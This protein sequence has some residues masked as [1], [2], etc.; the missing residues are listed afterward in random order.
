MLGTSEQGAIFFSRKLE[1]NKKI[2]MVI[3]LGFLLFLVSMSACE[4]PKSLSWTKYNLWLANN[5]AV[6]HKTKETNEINLS[7]QH[8]PSGWLAY[9]ELENSQLP[10]KQ[11]LLD[12]IREFY[13]C[14]LHFRISLESDPAK[15]KLLYYNIKDD[16]DYKERIEM[17]SFHA[18]EFIFI[19]SDGKHEPPMLTQYE[20]FNELRNRITLHCVFSPKWFV[21][22]KFEDNLK[23]FTL[24]FEDPY[25][26]MGINKFTFSVDE[27]KEIPDLKI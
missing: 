3:R 24:V 20:G 14:G 15:T 25:W 5:S 26:D 9:K 13:K 27:L 10:Y 21:C 2:I 19:E 17:L 22:E 18:D 6:Y 11:Y 1:L 12:S 7:A 8:I 16:V 23:D 4:Q